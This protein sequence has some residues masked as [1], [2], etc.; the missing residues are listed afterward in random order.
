[1]RV[2]DVLCGFGTMLGGVGAMALGGLRMMTSLFVIARLVL[3]GGFP[4]LHRCLFVMFGSR[5]VVLRAL[6]LVSCHCPFPLGVSPPRRI[7]S[8][9]A[10]RS[11]AKL[12]K[13]PFDAGGT[14]FKGPNSRCRI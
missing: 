5:T 11:E 10:N 4:V 7:T 9:R 14:P 13:T 1:M 12:D 6:V 8:Q 3:L 2:C